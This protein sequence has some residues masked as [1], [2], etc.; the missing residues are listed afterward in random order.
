MIEAL[1]EVKA[2]QK[3][4]HDGGKSICILENASFKR[5]SIYSLTQQVVESLIPHHHLSICV[6]VNLLDESVGRYLV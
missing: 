1:I 2:S 3:L 4:G 5:V 6:S